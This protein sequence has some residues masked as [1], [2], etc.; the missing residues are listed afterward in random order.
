M[1]F[2][3]DL[4]LARRLLKIMYTHVAAV[5]VLAIDHAP[6]Y[7]GG[8]CIRS[9]IRGQ[10]YKQPEHYIHVTHTELKKLSLE[11]GLMPD[12]APSTELYMQGLG[13]RIYNSIKG[14][15]FPQAYLWVENTIGEVER[16][17]VISSRDVL[18]HVLVEE[19]EHEWDTVGKDEV[20]AHVLEL[21]DVVHFQVLQ[22]EQQNGRNRLHD[23][24]LV[25]VDVQRDLGGL[26]DVGGGFGGQDVNQDV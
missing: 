11:N 26:D 25:A 14:L 3:R 12:L 17:E 20:L 19:L 7:A 18:H 15:I 24:L 16:G 6:T 22:E 10:E 4:V 8:A 9:P 21:V 2:K 23:D 1:S 13:M 5:L